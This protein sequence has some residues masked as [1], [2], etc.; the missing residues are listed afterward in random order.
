MESKLLDVLSFK[1]FPG[2]H[3]ISSHFTS[4][5]K[6]WAVQTQAAQAWAGNCSHE[7]K[8]PEVMKN[9]RC[10]NMFSNLRTPH[11]DPMR[12]EVQLAS[13]VGA[14]EP[15]CL[16]HGGYAARQSGAQSAGYFQCALGKTSEWK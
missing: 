10:F 14:P 12:L 9:R 3:H 7:F 2:A 6:S 11:D 16:E 4:T 15:T 1:P 5:S 13:L 8:I